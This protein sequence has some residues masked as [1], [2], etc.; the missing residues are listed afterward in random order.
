[1]S[2]F[3][4][5]LHSLLSSF[6]GII[7]NCNVI[8]MRDVLDAFCAGASPSNLKSDYCFDNYDSEGDRCGP[9]ISDRVTCFLSVVNIRTS[10]LIANFDFAGVFV[11][12]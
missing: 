8:H 9:V 7:N 10:F 3:C 11:S 4:L 1:M 2:R 5:V 6:N 12:Y